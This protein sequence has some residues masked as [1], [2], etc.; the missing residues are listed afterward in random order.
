L[1]VVKEDG[2]DEDDF[3]SLDA[4]YESEGSESIDTDFDVDEYLYD[5]EPSYKTLLAIFL[6]MTKI[7]ITKVY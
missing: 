5:D 7:L 3:S 6:Q 4:D 1:E 2:G